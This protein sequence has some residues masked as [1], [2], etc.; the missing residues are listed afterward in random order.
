MAISLYDVSVL[1]MRQVVGAALNVLDKGLAFAHE[2]GLDPA[3]LVE[4]RLAHDMFPLSFQIRSIAHH[5]FGA[6]QGVR[7]GVFGPPQPVEARTYEELVQLVRDAKAGLDA[8]SADEVN[9]LEGK[10]VIFALGDFKMPFVA[11]GF[12]MSFSLPNLYFHAATSYD[13]LRMKG[14]KLGKRDFMGQPRL[15]QIP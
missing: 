6:I 8:L 4:T 10:P 9:A 7:A 14:V 1:S 5:S 13:I 15:T 2:T 3:E 12:L 11:E